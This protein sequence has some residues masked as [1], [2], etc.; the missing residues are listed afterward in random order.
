MERPE[1]QQEGPP[2]PYLPLSGEATDWL[3]ALEIIRHLSRLY[4]D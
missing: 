1:K 3:A 2:P 4:R